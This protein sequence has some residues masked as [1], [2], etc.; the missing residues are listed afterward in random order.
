MDMVTIAPLSGIMRDETSARLTPTQTQRNGRWLRYYISNSLVRG[1]RNPKGWRLP[2]PAFELAV[3][4]AIA[5]HLEAR[6]RRH[7]ILRTTRTIEAEEI[8]LHLARIVRDSP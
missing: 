4:A 7:Q 8:A 1:K 3:T 6:A 2:A 5:D